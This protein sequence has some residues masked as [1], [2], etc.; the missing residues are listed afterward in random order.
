MKKI[1]LII[2]GI[3]VFGCSKDKE[4]TKPGAETIKKE[5]IGGFIEKGPF[6]RGSKVTLIDLDNDLN[7]TGKTYET[8]T[9]DDLGAFE[10]KNIALS[11]GYAKFAIDGFYFNEVTGKLSASR[12]VLNSIAQVNELNKINVNIITH[13]QA[14]RIL[15]LVKQDKLTFNMAKKQATKELLTGLGISEDLI[16][17]ADQISL[18]D[19]S[20]DAATLLALSVVLLSNPDHS[21]ASF[22]ELMSKMSGQLELDGKLKEDVK[23]KLR[24]YAAKVN[25]EQVASNLI[26][27]YHSLGLSVKVLEDRLSDFL[28]NIEIMPPTNSIPPETVWGE[29]SMIVAAWGAACESYATSME[30][31]YVIE[32]LYAPAKSY[33][34]ITKNGL[35]DFYKHQQDARNA[36]V[37]ELWNAT[38]TALTRINQILKYTKDNTSSRVVS[39]RKDALIL[40]GH[41]YYILTE[42]WGNVPLLDPYKDPKDLTAP[43]SFSVAE[44]RQSNLTAIQNLLNGSTISTLNMSQFGKM[45]FMAIGLQAKYN[46]QSGNYAE[47]IRYLEIL[48]NEPGF[49]LAN[50]SNIFADDRQLNEAITG[51]STNMP[52]NLFKSENFIQIA[53]KGAYVSFMRSTEI[54]LAAAEAEMQ[55][56]NLTKSIAYLNQVRLR[57]NKTTISATN[58][59]VLINYLLEEYKEDLGMEGLYFSALKRLGKAESVLNIPSAKKLMPIPQM[60]LLTNPFIAQN[61][62]Y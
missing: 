48:L 40:T 20:Q 1:L 9:T 42:T 33:E 15:K 27:R 37:G 12:I 28:E 4:T 16:L 24:S 46:L 51:Y 41:L 50:K 52:G 62:G 17:A 22:T 29:E 45:G 39:I 36:F 14:A 13:L 38:Y 57:N 2:M 23:S 19:G 7:P 10:F 5:K 34:G 31:Y 58:K 54:L 8:Q 3:L 25:P 11:S 6:V 53:K 56:G 32:A 26:N 18:T 44:I 21:D 30:K 60:E 35:T 55:S 59:E 43:K 49:K 47:A 61:P